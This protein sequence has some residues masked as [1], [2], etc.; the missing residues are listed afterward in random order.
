MVRVIAACRVRTVLEQVGR[1]NCLGANECDVDVRIVLE[2]VGR[3][4]ALGV[5]LA[6]PLVVVLSLESKLV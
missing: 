4:N 6:G 1:V 2:Q 5:M 3:A